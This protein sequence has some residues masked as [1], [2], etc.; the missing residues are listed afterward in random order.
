MCSANTESQ[1]NT[2]SAADGSE[3][4]SLSSRTQRPSQTEPDVFLFLLSTLVWHPQ[5]TDGYFSSLQN[6]GASGKGNTSS[7]APLY[8]VCK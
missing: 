6:H 8:L 7:L 2:A 5:L 3:E 4:A 1:A